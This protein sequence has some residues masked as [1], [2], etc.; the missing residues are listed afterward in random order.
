VTT[1]SH[2]RSTMAPRLVSFWMTCARSTA[3]VCASSCR[4]APRRSRPTATLRSMPTNIEGA[5]HGV[6]SRP[7]LNPRIPRL[8]LVVLMRLAFLLMLSDRL[9]DGLSVAEQGLE[10]AVTTLTRALSISRQSRT[11]LYREAK[12]LADLADAYLGQGDLN[13]ARQH[14]EEAVALASAQRRLQYVCLTRARVLLRCEGA[15]ARLAIEADLREVLFNLRESGRS[16]YEP[17]VHLERAELARLTGDEVA[18]K[19]ELR[20]AHRLF[21]EI[22]APIRA[23]Q[24]AKELTG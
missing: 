18:R 13:R 19:H 20:E 16:N 6:E 17:Y 3:S 14:A 12:L 24:L 5:H 7:R 9:R 23:A 8:R 2:G 4:S 10:Q 22:G 21:L 11:F 1:K 15:R